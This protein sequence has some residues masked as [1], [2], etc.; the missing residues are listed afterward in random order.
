MSTTNNQ[1]STVSLDWAGL[2]TRKK[3]Y[4]R[5]TLYSAEIGMV[6][7]C[8][9]CNCFETHSLVALENHRNRKTPCN[10]GK[11][12]CGG[13]SRPF[14]SEKAVRRHVKEGKCKGKTKA[15]VAS[16]LT[17]EVLALKETLVGQNATHAMTTKATV[18]ATL[19]MKVQ[20]KVDNSITNVG[21]EWKNRDWAQVP[22]RTA[23]EDFYNDFVQGP[24]TLAKWCAQTRAAE[25]VPENHNALLTSTDAK[26]MSYFTEGR[27]LVDSRDKVLLMLLETDLKEM[28]QGI[29]ECF[30]DSRERQG[31][32][33]RPGKTPLNELVKKAM[34]FDIK[35]LAGHVREAIK[36]YD[37]K[38]LQPIMDA[39][40]RPLVR[41]TKLHMEEPA[42][43]G[44]RNAE[45]ASMLQ[46]FGQLKHNLETAHNQVVS[47]A[48]K[49]KQKADD[50]V[51]ASETKLCEGLA[52]LSLA[53]INFLKIVNRI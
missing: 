35:Y 3:T 33:Y 22:M 53:Q 52:E 5:V 4:I 2:N 40:A 12:C 18:A 24:D 6:F 28:R 29:S 19:N 9:K 39:I 11:Y 25:D 37:I 47:D 48:H 7:T 27:W 14:A 21:D 13:C 44:E 26:T 43:K 42:Q 49:A 8:D 20:N 1:D 50:D 31:S 15:V 38:R 41:V 32:G 17:A 16:E 30:R 10:A 34:E 45:I 51:R 23:K 46:H 36:N